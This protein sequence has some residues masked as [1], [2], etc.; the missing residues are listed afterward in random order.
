MLFSS[1]KSSPNIIIIL[2]DDMGF[3]D[4]GSY[5]GE[6]ETPNL[7]DLANGECVTPISTMPPVAVQPGHL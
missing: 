3:S 7:D 5:G 2:V 4:V 1:G 6:I